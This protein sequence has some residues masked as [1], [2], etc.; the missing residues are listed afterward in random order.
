MD[1]NPAAIPLTRRISLE[2]ILVQLRR[3]MGTIYWSS[4]Y[5]GGKSLP[6]GSLTASSCCWHSIEVSVFRTLAIKYTP[7][8]FIARWLTLRTQEYVLV[9]SNAL[10]PEW[11]SVLVTIDLVLGAYNRVL[12]SVRRCGVQEKSQ[13]TRKKA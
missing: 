2:S 9:Q 13:I 6:A 1:L 11:L 10:H 12:T 5:I 8:F 3:P 4:Q 7:R